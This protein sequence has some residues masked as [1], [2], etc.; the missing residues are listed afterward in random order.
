MNSPYLAQAFHVQLGQ[1][2]CNLALTG[3]AIILYLSLKGSCCS[4]KATTEKADAK[5]HKIDAE[6]REL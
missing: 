1:V 4:E 3:A 5:L 6:W 2:T